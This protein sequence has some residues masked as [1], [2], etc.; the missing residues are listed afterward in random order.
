MPFPISSNTVFNSSQR[1]EKTALPHLFF[2]VWMFT[3]RKLFS[4]II[5]LLEGSSHLYFLQPT[6]PA[7]KKKKK[8][9][10]WQHVQLH[11]F[12]PS[13][14]GFNHIQALMEVRFLSLRWHLQS[15]PS[16]RPTC[17]S[18]YAVERIYCVEKALVGIS[19]SSA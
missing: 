4:Y 1:K 15:P 19:N 8:K 2:I 14:K 16:V 7:F 6:F 18:S 17:L 12:I 5:L 9:K 3:F 10:D 11:F 13:P